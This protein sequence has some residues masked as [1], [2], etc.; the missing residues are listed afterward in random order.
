MSVDI[1]QKCKVP[2]FEYFQVTH[3]NWYN[4]M[5][6][7]FNIA[8]DSIHDN[9]KNRLD[10]Q[11]GKVIVELN[12]PKFDIESFDDYN[13]K[14]TFTIAE[15]NTLSMKYVINDNNYEISIDDD[16]NA[17]NAA[18]DKVKILKD[19]LAAVEKSTKT[20]TASQIA[21]LESNQQGL[22]NEI[23]RLEKL[24]DENKI[25]NKVYNLTTTQSIKEVETQI[26]QL[27]SDITKFGVSIFE[28]IAKMNLAEIKNKHYKKILDSHENEFK[29]KKIVQTGENKFHELQLRQLEE[30]EEKNGE[31]EI[32]RVLTAEFNEKNREKMKGK[33]FTS[34]I[35]SSNVNSKGWLDQAELDDVK[36]KIK[37]DDLYA[38]NK[39]YEDIR[40]I[41]SGEE[42]ISDQ[43]SKI[44]SKPY[45][46]VLTVDSKTINDKLAKL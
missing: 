30:E 46:N 20:T 25:K 45:T 40:D 34:N 43:K 1:N 3:Q 18:M 14:V 17:L 36:Y 37:N 28:L 11:K 23:S 38:G 12:R 41:L 8:L 16:L 39:Y 6:G 15:L 33:E 24:N 29:L 31:E 2:A 26:S 35:G 42:A 7:S 21:D 27:Q 5:Q 9:F 4:F 44:F 13:K 10:A 22:K 19:A 32:V